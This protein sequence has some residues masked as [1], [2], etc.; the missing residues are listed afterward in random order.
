MSSGVAIFN[1]IDNGQINLLDCN[2][3]AERI[4]GLRKNTLL[5]KDIKETLPDIRHSALAEVLRRVWETGKSEH[6]PVARYRDN[7]LV[8]WKEYYIYKLP[9]GEV[10]A[11]FDDITKRKIDE[12][13]LLEYQEQ[14]RSLASALSLAEEQE[15]HNI[16]TGLHDQIGQTL[17]VLNMKLH[18]L[19]ERIADTGCAEQINAIQEALKQVIANTRSLTFELSPPIL[20]ELG[21][22]AAL[23]WLGEH[24]HRQHGLAWQFE[25]DGQPKPLGNDVKIVLFRSVR[26]LLI[27]IVK[28]AR[29]DAVRVGV[30]RLNG[31]I[32]IMVQDQGRGF[33]LRKTSSRPDNNYGFGLFNIR[34]RL[35]HLG[36]NLDIDTSPGHGTRITIMAPLKT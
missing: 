2:R 3:A 4:E 36:G 33:D 31:S 5:A 25:D 24:F 6:Y 18:S 19:R 17:S 15:R 23:E 28:H 22:E 12:Q 29:T 34:E 8:S 20:Y 27:N 14:L 11:V 13:K 1:V 30:C 7:L 21:L 35:R 10:I 26:E 32:R 9:A 16:A